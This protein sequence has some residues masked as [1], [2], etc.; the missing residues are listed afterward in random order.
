MGNSPGE[1]GSFVFRHSRVYECN[2]I[3]VYA[4]VKKCSLYAAVQSNTFN[5]VCTWIWK[6]VNWSARL[7]NWLF[8]V[9]SFICWHFYYST[10]RRERERE[11]E[12][13]KRTNRVNAFIISW[14]EPHKY[15]AHCRIHCHTTTWGK[16]Q[17]AMRTQELN[18]SF[19]PDCS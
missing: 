4:A 2:Y 14:S 10:S 5:Y 19:L 6:T 8:D 1:S 15:C 7:G 13:K 11:V 17:C 9:W 16:T 3:W 12:D 18:I